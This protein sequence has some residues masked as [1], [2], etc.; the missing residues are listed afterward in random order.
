MVFNGYWCRYVA[1]V[2]DV[3]RA[4]DAADLLVIAC[5]AADLLA[6]ACDVEYV[7]QMVQGGHQPVQWQGRL[8]LQRRLL[9]AKLEI[10]S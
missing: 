10:M 5:D 7:F 2:H 4:C 9:A 3:T 6:I 8:A 1:C